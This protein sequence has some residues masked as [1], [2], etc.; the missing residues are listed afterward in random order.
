MGENNE[1]TKITGIVVGILLFLIVMAAV[2][3][4]VMWATGKF[5][6]TQSKMQ[7]QVSGVENAIY[8]AYDETEISGADVLAACK[9]YKN[10]SMNIYVSTKKLNGSFYDFTSAS[11][12]SQL[13]SV[14]GCAAFGYNVASADQKPTY[15][16]GTGH[17]VDTV[18]VSNPTSNTAFQPLTAKGSESYV[19][20]NGKF[21]SSLVYDTDTGEVAGILFRQTK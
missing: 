20:Q 16:E 13:N 21:W 9:T 18:L 1:G 14:G 19:N 10:S 11:N 17:F 15:D 7:E 3:G 5:N 12:A 2:V 4:L 8:A 6:T